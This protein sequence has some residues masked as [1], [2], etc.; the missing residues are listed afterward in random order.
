MSFYRGSRVNSGN[1]TK[2]SATDGDQLMMKTKRKERTFYSPSFSM[3]GDFIFCVRRP[4]NRGVQRRHRK[5][6]TY[7]RM[8]AQQTVLTDRRANFSCNGTSPGSHPTSLLAELCIAWY[9]SDGAVQGG[10]TCRKTEA[11]TSSAGRTNHRGRNTR[12]P[13][14]T[15]IN[16]D[17]LPALSNVA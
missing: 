9:I 17:L 13:S 7:S 15:R 16:L 4:P 6:V 14:G 10:I 2:A 11:Q 1:T 8:R 12:S 3:E 5:S